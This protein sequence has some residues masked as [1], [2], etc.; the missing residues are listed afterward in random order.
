MAAGAALV[1]A[2]RLA[3]VDEH[4]GVWAARACR[5][6]GTPPVVLARQAEDALLGDSDRLPYLDGLLVG[7]NVALL[8]LLALAAEDGDV[9]LLGLEAEVLGKELE[10]PGDRLL[11]EVVVER[12]VAEHLEEGKVRRVADLVDVSGPDALLHVGKPLPR[13][14]LHGAHQ[15]RHERVHP[16]GREENGRVVFGYDRGSGDDDVPLRFEKLEV[17][18]PQF[19]SSKVFHMGGYYTVSAPRRQPSGVTP[20]R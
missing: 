20:T 3:G 6:G 8:A 1:A 18:V 16:G 12:P 2:L 5:A 11:L 9:Q 10:A 13:W 19:V 7:G 17:R 14:M 15:I 4:L